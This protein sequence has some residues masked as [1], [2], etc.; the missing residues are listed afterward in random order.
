MEE[1]AR[2]NAYVDGDLFHNLGLSLGHTAKSLMTTLC[3]FRFW[4][5]WRLSSGC[6]NHVQIYE[7]ENV[8]P[9]SPSKG[10]E[11][12]HVVSCPT[13]VL[14]VHRM[15]T[16]PRAPLYVSGLPVEVNYNVMSFSRYNNILLALEF[17]G[18]RSSEGSR[19]KKQEASCS[20]RVAVMK[21][22]ID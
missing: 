10:L 21:V 7:Q 3:F 5:R 11:F 8:R 9:C 13:S 15:K 22:K 17:A 6:H 20:G 2:N 18:D 14:A 4:H 19:R 1:S 12:Y 16:I